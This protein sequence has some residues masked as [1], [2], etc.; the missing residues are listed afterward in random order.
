[1]SD[2]LTP[3]PSRVYDSLIDV[4][5]PNCRKLYLKFKGQLDYAECIC[6]CKAKFWIVNR[7]VRFNLIDG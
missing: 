3:S 7:Q 4:R 2:R 5:C 1:M 6:R